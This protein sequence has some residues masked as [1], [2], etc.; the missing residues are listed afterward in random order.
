MPSLADSINKKKNNGVECKIQLNMGINFISTNDAGKI[1]TFHVRSDNEEIRSGNE[2]PEI[3]TKLIK[4][5][6]SNYQEEEKI[7]GN[8]SN[9]VFDIVDLLA[10]HIH[11]TNLKRGKSYIKSPEWILYKRA[12]ITPKNKIINV[13]NIQ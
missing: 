7:L 9:F 4:S 13:F 1:R 2:T 12:T 5:F 11:K 10:V 3:I 8:G 6:L